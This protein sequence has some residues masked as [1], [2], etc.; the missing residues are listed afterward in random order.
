MDNEVATVRGNHDRW[1]L[2]ATMRD[3][4]GALDVAHLNP[5]ELTFLAALPTTPSYPTQSGALLL[6]HGLGPDD[7]C[8]LGPDDFGYQDA[9]DELGDE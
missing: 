1:A 6:C 9:L 7:M 4:P 2:S 3:A 5:D 8:T